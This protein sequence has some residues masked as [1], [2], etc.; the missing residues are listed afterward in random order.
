MFR[1]CVPTSQWAGWSSRKSLKSPWL[2]EE[3]LII[4]IWWN[5]RLQTEKSVYRLM[6]LNLGNYSASLWKLYV[7]AFEV[8]FLFFCVYLSL[9]ILEALAKSDEHFVQNCTSLNS[10][11]EVIATDLQSKFTS[12]CSERIEHVCHRISSYGRVNGLNLHKIVTEV[13]AFKV[14]F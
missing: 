2:S 3:A 5:L 8:P 11:N 4:Q 13:V 10:L 7:L 14:T 9:Q 1:R 6:E 12:M